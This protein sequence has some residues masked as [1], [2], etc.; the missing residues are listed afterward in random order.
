MTADIHKSK[1]ESCGKFV[2]SF[3]TI[4]VSSETKTTL[5]CSKCYNEFVAEDTLKKVL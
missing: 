3:D 5:F 2:K 1:C 4:H